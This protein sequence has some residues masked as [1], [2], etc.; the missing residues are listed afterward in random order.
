MIQFYDHINVLI[1]PTEGCNLRCVYCFNLDNGYVHDLMKMETLEKLYSI[2]FPFYKSINIIWHG[3]EPTFAGVDFYKKALELQ[4]YYK[5]KYSVEVSN[6][7]QTN[8]TLLNEEFIS[9]IKKYKISLG[10]SFDGIVNSDTRNSTE[11]VLKA[12]QL[13]KDNNIIPG[14]ITVVTKKNINLMMEN[15]NYMKSLGIGIQ[16]NQYIEMNLN[17]PNIDLKL[18]INDYVD[19]MFELYLYWFN[20]VLCNIDV[21]PFRA[22]IEQYVFGQFPVCLH[23]SCM[24]SWFCMSHSGELMPCDKLFPSKYRYGNVY[25]YSDIREAYESNGYR[26]LLEA[27]ISRRKKCIDQCEYYQYCEGGCNHSA[28][29]EG[30][31][32]NI[33][34]FS[35]VAFKALFEKIIKHI[36]SLKIT[37]TDFKDKIKNPYLL[38]SLL[39]IVDGD[40]K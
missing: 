19:R 13:L 17:N 33:G 39:R 40:V 29:V 36:D 2:M 28:L 32:E 26:N 4:D 38:K 16:L 1:K 3:G 34:G 14:V 15:Y 23:S 27:A 7:M 5:R 24:R 30:E 21:N 20:D 10:I 31:I 9:L 37:R 22:Y 18:E 11:K 8:A 25:D 12:F 35:C 6:A